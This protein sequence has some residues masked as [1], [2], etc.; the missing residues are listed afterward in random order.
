MDQSN[1]KPKTGG[2]DF[3]FIFKQ[4]TQSAKPKK[5][6]IIWIIVAI[7]AGLLVLVF[8]FAVIIPPKNVT[9][10]QPGN[11]T[12]ASEDSLGSSDPI[13][14][15]DQYVGYL[16]SQ[17][18]EAAYALLSQDN[19]TRNELSQY[20]QFT[21]KYLN[22]I[23]LVNC[24]RQTKEAKLT[25]TDSVTIT[26]ICPTYNG[27]LTAVLNLTMVSQ[28]NLAKISNIYIEAKE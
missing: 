21:P 18:Y 9:T 14:T 22:N 19:Q 25:T 11:A 2:P 5:R 1:Q 28:S 10:N 15:A 6:P 24:E 26:F 17:N 4:P 23:D 8:I 12:Q 7:F 27:G 3:D 20:K 16:R 13:E